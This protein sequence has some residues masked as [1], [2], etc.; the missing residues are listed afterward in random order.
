MGPE[1][2]ALPPPDP[3][4]DELTSEDESPLDEV[5]S[6]PPAEASGLV[7]GVDEQLASMSAGNA[8]V[9]ERA[10]ESEILIARE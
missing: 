6:A 10:R 1:Q 8:A 9:M 2:A 5:A 4:P 3:D 7:W